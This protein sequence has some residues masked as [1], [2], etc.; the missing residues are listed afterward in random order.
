VEEKVR[1]V[2]AEPPVERLRLDELRLAFN[3]AGTVFVDSDTVPLNEFRLVS[4]IVEVGE[5]PACIQKL[6]GLR[7]MEKS[8]S[9]PTL[10]VTVVQWAKPPL[11]PVTF[12]EYVPMVEDDTVSVDEPDP[13]DDSVTDVWFRDAVNPGDDTDVDSATVPAKL[14]VLE[15]L[16]VVV[17]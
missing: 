2:S 8:G 14:F 6:A 15:R 4:R 11:V 3:P 9:A 12:T 16:I 5:E 10:T 17:P 7:E 1:L 13:P